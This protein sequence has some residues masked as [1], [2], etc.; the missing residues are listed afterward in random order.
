MSKSV[1][2]C[3]GDIG[4]VVGTGECGEVQ[5]KERYEERSRCG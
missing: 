4:R 1:L 2:G 3:G 5:V